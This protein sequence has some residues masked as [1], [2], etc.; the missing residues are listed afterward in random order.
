[1]VMMN[2][3][4]LIPCVLAILSVLLL[5]GC[6][7]QENPTRT[8]LEADTSTLTLFVG[9]SAF[10]AATTKAEHYRITY[11]SSNPAVATVDR[12]GKVTGVSEG[13]AV[14]TIDMAE[15][16][17]D[18]YAPKKLTYNVVVV[19][20]PVSDETTAA[21]PAPTPAPAPAPTSCTGSPLNSATVGMIICS[22]GK[23]HTATTGALS[24]GGKKVAI[25]AYKGVAGTVDTSAGSSGYSG[26]AIALNDAN[27]GAPC[28]WGPKGVVC[29]TNAMS[30][31]YSEVLVTTGDFCK[32]I[33]NTNRLANAD[34]FSGHDHAAAKAAKNYQYD[35]SVSAG[36]HPTGTSQWFLPTMYQWNLILKGMCGDHGDLRLPTVDDSGINDNYKTASFDTNITA[37][38]G[39]SV[40]NLFFW[41]SI[42]YDIDASWGVDFVNGRASYYTKIGNMAYVRAVL[43]F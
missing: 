34:C 26:L 18:W 6:G 12:M 5:S 19:K 14:I 32:G 35:A 40:Q 36:A 24:C 10:R 13:E 22:H 21:V 23:V 9:E 28:Q 20:K 2:V 16:I 38:G 7:E 43:A 11:T 39:T 30:S 8:S 31:T 29:N 27:G 17:E 41:P 15:S 37:A 42:E 33:D 3:K 1:M 4:H 25:V